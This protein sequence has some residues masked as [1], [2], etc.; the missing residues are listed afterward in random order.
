MTE[1]AHAAGYASVRRFNA[2]FRR[3]FGSS[4]SVLRR[5][6]AGPRARDR[7]GLE[8][9]LV[10][11]A[12]FDWAAMLA[13]LKIRQVPSVE[14]AH[15]TTWW[16]SIELDGKLATLE[17]RK[18]QPGPSDSVSVVP[19][20]VHG[21]VLPRALVVVERVRRMLDLDAD[22]DVVT[23]QLSSDPVLAPRV[24]QLPGVRIAGA[25]DGFEI[26]VRAVLGQQVSVAAAATHVERLVQRCGAK[27]P[28][29]R[30]S[31]GDS[32]A[33]VLTHCFP[34]AIAV[35]A[36]PVQALAVPEARARALIALSREV[37]DGHIALDGTEDPSAL[38]AKLCAIPGVGPWTAEYVALRAGRDP[39]AF[40]SSD[41]GLRRALAQGGKT[42]SARDAEARAEPWRPFRGYAAMLLW[43]TE[44]DHDG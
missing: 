28:A 43:Q 22:P 30:A 36:L 12:P 44:M 14:H 32:T 21:P 40:P 18:P 25:W 3:S 17:I 24:A 8:L 4:P 9:G 41:L 27:R 10:T 11:R 16:R 1:I 29:T 13:Y 19:V 31:R 35:A 42:V 20:V 38:R 39:D 2:A 6:P 34:K 7:A 26:A 15:G 5:R 23:S 37:S 33:R